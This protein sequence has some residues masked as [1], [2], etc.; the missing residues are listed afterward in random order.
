M[1]IGFCFSKRQVRQDIINI[2]RLDERVG[3]LF[4]HSFV[5]LLNYHENNIYS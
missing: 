4:I 2:Y 1:G 3:G 5:N